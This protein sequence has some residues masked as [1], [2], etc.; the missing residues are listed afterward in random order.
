MKVCY[1]NIVLET[2]FQEVSVIFVHIINT[3]LKLS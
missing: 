2:V 1:S 3:K